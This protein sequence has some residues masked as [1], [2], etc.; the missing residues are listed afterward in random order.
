MRSIVGLGALGVMVTMTGALAQESRK[1]EPVVVTATTVETPAEQLGASVTVVDGADFQTRHYPTVDEA[2]RKVPGVEIER[3][4][5]FGKTTSISIRGLNANQVQVLIDGV[6]VKSPTLGQVDLSDISPDLIDRIEVIRGPQSTLYGADAIGGVVNIITKKGQGPA[7]GSVQ[8]EAG[9]RDTLA[10]R[11]TVSGNYKIL[12]YAL[13]ASYFETNGQFQNDSSD[14]TSFATRL[15]L[16]LP[17]DSA[18]T[19]IARYNH[20]HTGLPVKFVQP[21]GMP[22][23]DDP[24]I[25]TNA[26]QT[27][28]TSVVSLHGRTRPVPW[29]ESEARISRYDNRLNFVDAPDQ[30]GCPFTSCEFPARF[31]VDRQ[32][33]AW[34]NHFYAGKWSTSTVGLE[35]RRDH[36][37]AQGIGVSPGFDAENHT[38]SAFFEQQLRFF[39]RLFLSGGVRVED[40][41]VFG[42]HTTERGSLAFVIKETGT[43]LRGGAGSGFRAP[44]LNDLF[45]PGFSNLSVKPERSFSWDFGIDQSLWKNRL[46]FGL[47]YFHNVVNDLIT[48]VAIPVP[49]FVTVGNTNTARVSGIEFTSEVDLLDTLTAFVNYTYTNSDNEAAHRPLARQPFHRWNTGLTWQPTPRLSLFTEAHVVTRQ[50]EPT[51]GIGDLKLGVYNPGYARVDVGGTYR[52]LQRHAFLQGLDLTARIQNVL[53]E[54][55]AEVRGFPALGITALVGLRA[56]F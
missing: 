45:F 44:T 9:N 54:S 27:S 32:E 3:S 8:A 16:T 14:R 11:G 24:V 5:S 25:D 2:L 23:P 55:Y 21:F 30:A 46:R 53:D 43:K 6:R 38:K 40:N 33:A 41:S 42:T 20:A 7:A 39:D 29:W 52:L 15:G 56:S 28:E 47:T 51:G 1:L 50:W 12:D 37:D 17:Y 18:L 13:S 26:A 22:L 34:L 19:F 31:R 10:S 35:Y 49:P 4:G 36:G 48:T